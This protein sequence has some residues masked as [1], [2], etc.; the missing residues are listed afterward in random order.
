[1]SADFGLAS[2]AEGDRTF[3]VLSGDLDMSTAPQVRAAVD[4]ITTANLTID[5]AGVP[6]MDSSGV[7]VIATS[8]HRRRGMGGAVTLRAVQPE[9]MR[10]FQITGVADMCP[11]EAAPDRDLD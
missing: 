10:V 7:N 8:I 4:E 2:Y 5:M 3:L 9:P 11:F 6:F 1:M